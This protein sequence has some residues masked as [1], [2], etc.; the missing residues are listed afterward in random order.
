MDEGFKSIVTILTAITGVAILALIVSTRSN[1][2]A[3]IQAAA[4]GYGNALGVAISPVTGATVNPNLSY[5]AGGAT[6]GQLGQL[7]GLGGSGYNLFG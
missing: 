5:P 1:T 6:L 7:G 3:V 4:S 2:A